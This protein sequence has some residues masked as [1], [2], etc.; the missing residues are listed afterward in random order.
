MELLQFITQNMAYLKG[1]SQS[2]VR[3]RVRTA[4][5]TVLSA[6]QRP[7]ALYMCV[8]A[9]TRTVEDNF[10]SPFSL[11]P[12]GFWVC[13]QLVTW[14]GALPLPTLT[15]WYKPTPCHCLCSEVCSDPGRSHLLHPG[16]CGHRHTLMPSQLPSLNVCT[17]NRVLCSGAALVMIEAGFLD[18]LTSS[19]F[20]L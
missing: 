1:S 10:Q 16:W 11:A 19:A 2:H 14:P 5:L 9:C 13:G 20:V 12:G 6:P 15:L 17:D 8:R 4:R 3:V 7:C 18:V